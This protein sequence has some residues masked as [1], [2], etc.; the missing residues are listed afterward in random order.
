MSPLLTEAYM[1]LSAGFPATSGGP[2]LL[3]IFATLVKSTPP[4][5][6]PA[7]APWQSLQYARR[8]GCTSLNRTTR[9]GGF[10]SGSFGLGFGSGS[11]GFGS[12]SLGLASG[13]GSLGFGSG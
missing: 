3:R 9:D 2:L 6:L 7:E 13:S 11:F 5:G 8:M 12:G 10:G 1:V 4:F